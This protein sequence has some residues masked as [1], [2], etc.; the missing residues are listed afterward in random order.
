MKTLNS[1][2][3]T[4]NF[5]EYYLLYGEEEYLKR[6]YRNRLTAG[7]LQGEPE[8]NINYRHYAG[9]S[10]DV[11][12][13]AEQACLTPFFSDSLL[14]VIED[15][16]LFKKSNSLA[17][18][19]S[20]KADSTKIIFV[21]SEIDKRN[22]LFKYIKSHGVVC[23]INHK[24]DTELV[25]WIASYLKKYDCVITGRAAKLI[26]SKAGTDMQ[27]LINEMDKLISYVGEKKQIDTEDVESICT[28]LLSNHIFMMMDYIVSGKQ[29]EALLLYKD[30]LAMKESPLSILFLLTRHYNILM[31]IK[32]LVNESDSGI[33]KTLSVPSFSIK[34]YKSQ[35][36]AY[37]KQQL[38]D[39]LN[40]CI[41]TEE[42]IKTGMLAPQ[43]GTEMQIIRLSSL[44]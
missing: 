17:D 26:I 3:Q 38:C 22:A 30:L 36:F 12:I 11:D 19:L 14:I 42:S 37:T 24:S 25:P 43:I 7:I 34:K 40:W 23:E 41:E 13:I 15:S 2:I 5:S 4:G 8:G 1:H 32:E 18:R 6:Y 9:D 28:T 31:H 35:A 20:G 21:E 29:K 39:I 10:A 27:M 16:G 33:A 44:L